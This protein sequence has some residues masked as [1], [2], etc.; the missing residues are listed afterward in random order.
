MVMMKAKAC[1]VGIG[2]RRHTASLNRVDATFPP[3]PNYVTFR[4]T[5]IWASQTKVGLEREFCCEQQ[6]RSNATLDHGGNRL[7]LEACDRTGRRK[8]RKRSFG[9]A[10]MRD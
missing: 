9:L 4:S 10:V 8:K 7:L 2:W 3:K 6:T 5:V 1:L